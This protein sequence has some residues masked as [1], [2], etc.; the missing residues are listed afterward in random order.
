MTLE[1]VGRLEYV[2]MWESGGVGREGGGGLE[3]LL[4]FIK[5]ERGAEVK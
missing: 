4:L 2:G 3:I 1:Y 5:S